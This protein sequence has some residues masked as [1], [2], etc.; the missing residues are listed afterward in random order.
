MRAIIV[1]AVIVLVLGLVGWLRFSSPDG[2]PTIRIDTDKVNDD[3][4]AIVERSK[5]AVESI[6]AKVE[7]SIDHKPAETE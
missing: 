4:T 5:E 1:I 2:D 7:E 6:G 3:T